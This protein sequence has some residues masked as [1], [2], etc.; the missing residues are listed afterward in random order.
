MA[1]HPTLV[2]LA[3]TEVDG[4]PTVLD[5]KLLRDL[6]HKLPPQ[7]DVF[8]MAL[9]GMVREWIERDGLA[10]ACSLLRSYTMAVESVGKKKWR[11]W[12]RRKGPAKMKYVV[13]PWVRAAR[14]VII[15]E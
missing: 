8:S 11:V 1:Y 13:P 3:N 7:R 14:V 12:S 4:D 10:V 2:D 15:P 6:M 5:E 9:D